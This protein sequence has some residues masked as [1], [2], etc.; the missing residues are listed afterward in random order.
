MASNAVI[1]LADGESTP[2]DHTF[3]PV[4]IKDGSVAT[5]QNK[6]QTLVSGREQLVLKMKANG[7]VRTVD[8]HLTVPRVMTETINEVEV[9]TVPDFATCK[10]TVIVPID[11]PVQSC[12]NARTLLGQAVL[13]A[14]VAAMA[15]DAEFVW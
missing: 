6:A 1:V 7:K 13:H 15:D 9:S 10:A 3:Q 4:A 14:V 12:E 11:W 8:V 5:Y 2:V